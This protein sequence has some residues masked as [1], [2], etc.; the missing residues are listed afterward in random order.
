[1][2]RFQVTQFIV[3][4]IDF[5]DKEEAGVASINQFV[6]VVFNKI[7]VF[8]VGPSPTGELHFQCDANL[9]GAD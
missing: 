9:F 6:I 1:M 5:N 8:L 3:R 2:N 4:C 7:G